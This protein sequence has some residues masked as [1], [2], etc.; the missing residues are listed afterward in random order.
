M[1]YYGAT[2]AET[3]EPGGIGNR[4]LQNNESWHFSVDRGRAR[5][6]QRYHDGKGSKESSERSRK[7]AA[8]Q[9]LNAIVACSA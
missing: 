3:G 7:W 5:K 1:T 4:I 9:A 6:G 8:V 2:R